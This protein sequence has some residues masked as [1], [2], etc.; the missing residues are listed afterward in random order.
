[1]LTESTVFCFGVLDLAFRMLEMSYPKV[2]AV[3]ATPWISFPP[4]ELIDQI[5]FHH[6]IH[7]S[8]DKIL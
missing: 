2:G 1:M 5:E 7:F 6:V 3:E 8:K 4:P